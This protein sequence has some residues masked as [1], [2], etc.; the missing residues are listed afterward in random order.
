MFADIVVWLAR[1]LHKPIKVRD[2]TERTFYRKFTDEVGCTPSNFLDNRRL[3][4][5]KQLLE[6]DSVV[7]SICTK[8][9]YKSELGFRNTFEAK[10]SS[11]SAL[12][13]LIVDE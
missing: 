2:M 4:R 7:K 8:V 1:S 5:R 9:G 12:H 13:K 10:Y 3:F 6:T 11:S